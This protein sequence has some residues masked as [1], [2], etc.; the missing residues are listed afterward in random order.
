MFGEIGLAGEV[1]AV[2]LP[3][4]RL[5]EAKKLGFTRCLLPKQ[6][7]ERLTD[8][9]GLEIVPIARLADALQ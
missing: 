2:G 5:A 1:R 3:E 4:L 9:H 6:N 8:D 7:V